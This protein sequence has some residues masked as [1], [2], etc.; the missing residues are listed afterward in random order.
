[1]FVESSAVAFVHTLHDTEEFSGGVHDR[2]CEDRSRPKSAAAVVLRIEARIGVGVADVCGAES[3]GH[4]TC[5]ADSA[6]HFDTRRAHSLCEPGPEHVASGI[7]EED[8]GALSFD[9][10]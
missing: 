8:A 7:E 3:R 5:Y 1:M 9:D 10:V 2:C 6:R 4:V